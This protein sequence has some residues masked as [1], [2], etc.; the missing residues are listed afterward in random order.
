MDYLPKRQGGGELLARAVGNAIEKFQMR[1]QI[2]SQ[3]AALEESLRQYQMLLEAMP[4]MVWMADSEGNVEYANRR[5]LEYT[6]PKAE[7]KGRLLWDRLVHPEDLARTRDTWSRAVESGSVFEIEHRLLRACDGE[8]RWHLVRAVPIRNGEGSTR[9]FGTCTEIDDQKR[10]EESARQRQKLESIGRLAGG[11]AHDFNNLLVVILGG[12]SFASDNL[13]RDHSLQPMLQSIVGAGERAAQ[14]TRQILAY[15]GKANL[16]VE[17]V[18]LN[19][20]IRQTCEG[21][22]PSLPPTVCLQYQT[23]PGAPPVK[24]DRAQMRQ[25]ITDLVLNAAE[26]LDELSGTIRVSTEMVEAGKQSEWRCG[27]GPPEIGAGMHVAL[28]VWDTGCGMD[29]ETRN[30]M[31]DPF[32]STKGAGR[33]LGLASVQ[34]FV[35][36]NRGGIHVV[37]APGAGTRFR[38]VLPAAVEPNGNEKGG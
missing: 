10:A 33:G 1:R 35:R 9:W 15:A 13:P 8:R 14:L 36:S 30:K 5:W 2:E 17:R 37:S 20:L 22:R 23:T 6:A 12:A 31:F 18:D 26:A 16:F 28:E 29:E 25:A 11:I 27:F 21:M 4:Q 32:F 34:G 24:T 3:G 19:Q 7:G 38:I